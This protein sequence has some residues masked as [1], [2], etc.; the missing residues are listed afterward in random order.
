MDDFDRYPNGLTPFV[1]DE[2]NAFER[3]RSPFAQG[4]STKSGS[5]DGDCRER[6]LG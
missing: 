2:W 5:S 4:E 3:I 1:S 6:L